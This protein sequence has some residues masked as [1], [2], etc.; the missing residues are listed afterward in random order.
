[1]NFNVYNKNAIF[2]KGLAKLGIMNNVM[3][4]A[5]RVQFNNQRHSWLISSLV[6]SIRCGVFII[7]SSIGIKISDKYIGIVSDTFSMEYR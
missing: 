4:M 5:C 6:L 7:I 2:N 3:H 1:M